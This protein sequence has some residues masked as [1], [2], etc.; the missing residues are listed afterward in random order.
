MN[1]NTKTLL[2]FAIAALSV[3][4]LYA[5]MKPIDADIPP[6]LP[7]Q[8]QK[9]G[10]VLLSAQPFTLDEAAT[11]YWRLEQPQYDAGYVLVL[12]VDPQLVHP[13]QTAEPI[14]YV[15]AETANRV[16]VGNESGRVIAIVPAPLGADGMPSLDLAQSPIFFGTAELPERID[17]KRAAEEL[18]L[19]RK[20]GARPAS[21]ADVAAATKPVVG[22]HDDYDLRLFCSDLIAQH[23]PTETDLVNG[24]RAPR[25]GR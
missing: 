7:A 1:R 24:L 20:S 19:A 23:S 25:V 10:V 16:N 15:G 8:P 12:Q 13:R 18:A 5:W 14:L 11:H 21:A 4:G 22:F 2:S 6:A 3:S 17:A 9:S